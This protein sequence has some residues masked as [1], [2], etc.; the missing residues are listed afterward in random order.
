MLDDA[1]QIG[2]RPRT[3]ARQQGSGRSILSST[4]NYS[5]D[6][7]NKTTSVASRLFGLRLASANPACGFSAPSTSS[8]RQVLPAGGRSPRPAA[9]SPL[10]PLDRK[11]RQWTR[12]RAAALLDCAS[13]DSYLVAATQEW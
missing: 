10:E 6:R 13:I 9:F 12:R 2:K 11:T 5:C 7:G 4:N 8:T 1:R 3:G